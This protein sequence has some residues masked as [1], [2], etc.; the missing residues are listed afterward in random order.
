MDDDEHEEDF[1]NKLNKNWGKK[2]VNKVKQTHT[3][4]W[5]T[6]NVIMK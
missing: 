5:K 6:F 1:L 3:H 4:T 2:W